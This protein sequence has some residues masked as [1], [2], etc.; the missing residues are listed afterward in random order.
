MITLT[1]GSDIA[2]SET[3]WLKRGWL[4]K[5]FRQS[6]MSKKQ[7]R[8]F[9]CVQPIR[10][11]SESI[12]SKQLTKRKKAVLEDVAKRQAQGN[13]TQ[14]DYS[15]IPALSDRQLTQFKRARRN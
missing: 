12:W 4:L 9:N 15:D 14:I 6:Q 11:S 8:Q 5:T 10:K 13:D 7:V 1:V 2:V 3:H